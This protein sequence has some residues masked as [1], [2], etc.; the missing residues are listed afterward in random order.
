MSF[1][2]SP[3]R[4]LSCSSASF[5]RQTL[6]S[7]FKSL[8]DDLIFF[9][10]EDKPKDSSDMAFN[11]L[12]SRAVLL[13]DE[14][15][16]E[17]GEFAS[18][19]ASAWPW[20]FWLENKTSFASL[21]DP[22]TGNWLL[23][24]SPFPQTIIIASYVYFVTS[25]GPRLMENRKPFDLKRPMIIYNFSI[26]VFSLY[27]IYEVCP[28]WTPSLLHHTSL[29]SVCLSFSLSLTFLQF[30][31]SGWANGYT[32]GCDIVD[33][34]SSPQ[35]LRVCEW[36]KFFPLCICYCQMTRATTWHFLYYLVSFLD[37]MDLLAVLLLQV[38]WDAWHCKWVSFAFKTSFT[39]D[40]R[41]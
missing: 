8:A 30:L 5:F 13:Y 1:W 14:W 2:E 12:T 4:G 6:T 18:A 37:G 41:C 35:A 29:V 31:M 21:L 26:V 34:S 20:S 17:A 32:Y 28:S 23:M 3:P 25:L 11:T 39:M 7:L 33:Y 24:A 10:L 36:S 38:H 15:I 27:M 22:R 9:S 19:S 16:K 40:Y